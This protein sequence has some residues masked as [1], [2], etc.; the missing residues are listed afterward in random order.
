[1]IDFVREFNARIRDIDH[2]PLSAFRR[3]SI[4]FDGMNYPYLICAFD[5][6]NPLHRQLL[7]ELLDAYF[8]TTEFW[9]GW[10]SIAYQGYG[11]YLFRPEQYGKY[12]GSI[13]L[14][15]FLGA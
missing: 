9:G 8:P 2:T 5:D 15:A 10:E 11:A 4:V 13:T 3:S 12:E 14:R 1:M 7:R 6:R